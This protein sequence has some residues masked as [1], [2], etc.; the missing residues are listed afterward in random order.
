MKEEARYPTVFL[1]TGKV[2]GGKTSYLL[3]LVEQLKHRDF[4]VGG[5]LSP[6][7]FESGERSGF[8]L[9]NIQSGLELTL[10]SIRKTPGWFRYRRFWFNPD[11]FRQGREWISF[12]L[13]EDP[14]V[15][16]IDEVGP[17]EL[18]GSGWSESLVTLQNSPA[19]IQVWS[20]RETLIPE[21]GKRWNLPYTRVI[22]IEETELAMAAEMISETIKKY[23]ALK[24]NK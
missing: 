22:Q 12:S 18:E 9:Q 24:H 19:P 2:H 20:V 11:A 14:D 16:V 3:K 17:M 23:K 21:L 8:R 10:A 4:K 13:S 1:V 5:F 6:G 15:L 7:S